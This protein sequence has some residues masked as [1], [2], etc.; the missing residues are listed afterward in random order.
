MEVGGKAVKD[1]RAMRMEKEREDSGRLKQIG[2]D[3]LYMIKIFSL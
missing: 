1:R 3:V 2:D